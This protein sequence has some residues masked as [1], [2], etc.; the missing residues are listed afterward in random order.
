MISNVGQSDSLS[1]SYTNVTEN[2]TSL[3]K[4][5]TLPW[6]SMTLLILATERHND[7]DKTT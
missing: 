6:F 4:T 2:L 1:D 5:E 3:M 7:I